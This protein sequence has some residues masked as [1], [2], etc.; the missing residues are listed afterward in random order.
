[1]GKPHAKSGKL[2]KTVT[3]KGRTYHYHR[4][5]MKRL[6]DDISDP[7]VLDEAIRKIEGAERIQSSMPE[8]VGALDVPETRAEMI[9]RHTPDM[10]AFTIP[11]V[12]GFILRAVPGDSL[13]YHTGDLAVDGARDELLRIRQTYLRLMADFNL[14]HLRQ[15]RSRPGWTH[16]FATR[17]REPLKGVP[18]HALHADISPDEYTALIAVN[19]RQSAK[20]VTRTIRDALGITDTAAADLRNEMIRRG[21]LTLG[22]PPELTDLGLHLLT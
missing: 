13:L 15:Q 4:P 5:T 18:R 6:P 10:V 17:S 22:R 2:V 8:T 21:W 1:M 12:V 9:P 20:S 16:Y 7:K 3:A 11:A 14:V 19:E